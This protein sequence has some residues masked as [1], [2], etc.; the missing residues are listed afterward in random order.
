MGQC[1]PEG[2][3]PVGAKHDAATANQPGQFAVDGH[4]TFDFVV[5]IRSGLPNRG[6]FVDLEAVGSEI[7]PRVIKG[8]H[9]VKSSL[10]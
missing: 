9:L 3:K 7:I 5:A 1:R 6:P 2:D 10:G 8:A 4:G